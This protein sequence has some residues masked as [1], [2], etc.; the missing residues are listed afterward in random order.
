MN[1]FGAGIIVRTA[2]SGVFTRRKRSRKSNVQVPDRIKLS[3][4]Q[5]F[6]SY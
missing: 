5:A 4:V 3:G 6:I 1:F 2:E